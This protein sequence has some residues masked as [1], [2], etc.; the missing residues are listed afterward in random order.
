[1]KFFA[2]FAAVLAVAASHSSWTLHELGQAIQD[3]NTDPAMIPHLEAALD[4]MMD[5][6]YA[7]VTIEAVTVTVPAATVEWTLA[8][9]SDALQNPETDPA[10]IPALEDA[11]NHLMD[12]IMAGN[13]VSAVPVAIPA[14]EVTHWSLHE[15]S[16]ALQNPATN[17]ALIPY[18]EHALND[19]MD[20]IYAGHEM[21][22]IVVAIPAGLAPAA[23]IPVVVAP[24]EAEAPVEAVPEVPAS[25]P[26]TTPLVQIIVNIKDKQ[27]AAVAAPS[28]G[29]TPRA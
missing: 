19:M 23:P 9:L 6:I 5:Q 22:A 29:P 18:L 25:V 20:A 10:L 21:E 1:M 16:E 2:V 28:F 15:L 14:M 11:L 13:E 27:A 17:P 4:H 3:P 26:S 24:V 7:G 12:S 8:Q